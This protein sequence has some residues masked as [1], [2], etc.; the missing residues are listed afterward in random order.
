MALEATYKAYLADP[1]AEAFAEDATLN[2]IPTTTSLSRASVIIKHVETQHRQVEKKKENF[3]NV[4]ESANS[5]CVET[6][7]TLH[8]QQ[9]GGLYLLNLDDNFLCDKVVT[10]PIVSTPLHIHDLPVAFS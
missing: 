7:T 2:Y 8:F 1:S 6:E 3:L 9:G 10:I 4:I 5:L